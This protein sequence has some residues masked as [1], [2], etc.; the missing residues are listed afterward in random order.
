MSKREPPLPGMTFG[1]QAS[2]G[3]QVDRNRLTTR[4][5]KT[6]GED[7]KIMIM[8]ELSMECPFYGQRNLRANLR[9]HG[10]PIGRKRIR[11]LMRS[12]GLCD[13]PGCKAGRNYGTRGN[14]EKSGTRFSRKACFPSRP[15]SL[16]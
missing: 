16:M 12:M 6:A 1:K 11:R 13:R 8:A 3:F 15:S 7:C 5:T 9:D 2:C 4:S 10:Y 14:L